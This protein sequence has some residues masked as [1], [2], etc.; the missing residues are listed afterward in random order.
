MPSTI[1]SL[2]T[3]LSGSSQTAIIRFTSL[4]R[5]FA[6][7]LQEAIRSTLNNLESLQGTSDATSCQRVVLVIDRMVDPA[8]SQGKDYFQR[9]SVGVS[10]ERVI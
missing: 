1:S 3:A 2:V 9:G 5:G 6:E 7:I 4:K 10:I 8:S